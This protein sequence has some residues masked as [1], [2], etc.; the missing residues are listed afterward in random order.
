MTCDPGL[1]Y[2]VNVLFHNFVGGKG[3]KWKCAGVG[4]GWGIEGTKWI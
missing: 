2:D 3:W 4:V 1:R